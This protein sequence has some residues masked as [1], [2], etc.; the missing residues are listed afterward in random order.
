MTPKQGFLSVLNF[1]KYKFICFI[2]ENCY[3]YR[4]Y[5]DF[6]GVLFPIYKNLGLFENI[7]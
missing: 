5:M 2:Y 6:K 1:I 4:D 3:S 7:F